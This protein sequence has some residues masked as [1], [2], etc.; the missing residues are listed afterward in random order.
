MKNMKRIIVVFLLLGSFQPES[1]TLDF[2]H[3]NVSATSKRT[4]TPN[5]ATIQFGVDTK[6]ISAKIAKN[7]NAKVMNNVIK[8]IKK[9]KISKQDYQTS[10]FNINE[11][12]KWEKSIRVITGYRVSN[13]I[14]IKILKLDNLTPLIDGVISIGSNKIN[15]LNF[16]HTDRNII[17]NQV[18]LEAAKKA[19]D[20]ANKVA[21]TIGHTQAVVW[22]LS[23]GGNTTYQPPVF[24]SM[25]MGRSAM[26]SRNTPISK[27]SLDINATVNLTAKLK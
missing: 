25:G 19:L 1:K 21:I 6:N 20:K 16:D 12:S 3:L 11:E 15:S 13:T 22:Q 27:G 8:Q 4:I 7:E 2:P 17:Y 9:L 23:E 24:A 26:E 10:G 14:S 5:M 18:L